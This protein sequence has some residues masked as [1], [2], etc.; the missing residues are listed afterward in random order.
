M[1]KARI[2][3]DYAAFG[4]AVLRSDATADYI[5]HAAQQAALDHVK[6]YRNE[7]GRHRRGATMIADSDKETRDGLLTRSIGGLR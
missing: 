1:M 7:H 4:A 3:T 5:Y 6:A 2:Q